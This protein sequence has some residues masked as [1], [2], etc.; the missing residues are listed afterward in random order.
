MLWELEVIISFSDGPKIIG[1]CSKK[2]DNWTDLMGRRST[3]I[4]ADRDLR[5]SVVYFIHIII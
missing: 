5:N 1:L 4:F 2:K 3:P